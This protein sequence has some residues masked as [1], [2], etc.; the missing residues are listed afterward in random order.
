MANGYFP[1]LALAPTHRYTGVR[2]TWH[3][4]CVRVRALSRSVAATRSSLVDPGGLGTALFS[5]F[6]KED[7][8]PTRRACDRAR[9]R[10][11]FRKP[12]PPP[13]GLGRHFWNKASPRV[14]R[15][16]SVFPAPSCASA[17][18]ARLSSSHVAWQNSAR[19]G[20]GARSSIVE[21]GAL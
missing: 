7:E 17:P 1:P 4:Q 10:L 12:I 19:Q 18:W 9:S 3:A 20:S 14:S 8:R 21:P 5:M 15:A 2:A 6:T 13:Y 16:F 11:Q